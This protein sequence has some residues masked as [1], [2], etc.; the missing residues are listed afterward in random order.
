MIQDG[1]TASIIPANN[2]GVQQCGGGSCPIPTQT[3]SSVCNPYNWFYYDSKYGVKITSAQTDK[4]EYHPGNPVTITGTVQLLRQDLY[5]NEC[6][7]I[8]ALDPVQ[9]NAALVKVGVTGQFGGTITNTGGSFTAKVNVPE[10]AESSTVTYTVTASYSS[11]H[12]SREVSFEVKPYTPSLAVAMSDGSFVYPGDQCT[13]SG[14]GWAPNGEVTLNYG[15]LSDEATAPV[16]GSGTFNAPSITVPPDTDEGDSYTVTA[17]ESLLTA[18]G[19]IVVKW[20][21]LSVSL[22]VSPASAKQGDNA[23]ISGTVVD[24]EG[25]GV[26]ASVSFLCDGLPEPSALTTD[27]SGHFSTEIAIPNDAE[28]RAH[29]I[30]VYA[31]KTGGY[32]DASASASL[33]VVERPVPTATAVG[34]AAGAAGLGAA[35]ATAV[36]LSSGTSSEPGQDDANKSRKKTN[37]FRIRILAGGDV[38]VGLVGGQNVNVQIQEWDDNAPGAEPGETGNWGRMTTYHFLGAGWNV[39]VG[40]NRFVKVQ[41]EEVT[42]I[43][44]MGW[45]RA[46]GPIPGQTATKAIE[47]V[48]KDAQDTGIPGGSARG[49]SDWR[50]FTTTNLHSLEDFGGMGNVTKGPSVTLGFKQYNFTSTHLTFGNGE[51]VN[52][53][54]G[55]VTRLGLNVSLAQCQT[56]KWW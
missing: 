4:A 29:A 2:P 42:T 32:K 30:K 5:V 11:A 8:G 55:L 33:Q 43:T 25:K 14:S 24:N 48:M 54:G 12:D 37:Q 44:G 31:G 49:T 28:V 47:V 41:T 22:V 17:T 20:H 51:S 21:Q 39:G 35:G 18:K 38:G 34:L 6:G 36:G 56:G 40:F 9:D 19:T 10:T 3:A 16:D 45:A 1:V 23:T 46:G 7:E 15:S 52:L 26:E 50:N 53:P 27:A 13:V